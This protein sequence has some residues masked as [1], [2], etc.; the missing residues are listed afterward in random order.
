[1]KKLTVVVSE[2]WT[3]IVFTQQQTPA[4]VLCKLFVDFFYENVSCVHNA[5]KVFT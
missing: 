1:M 4:T 3:E 2:E 5:M